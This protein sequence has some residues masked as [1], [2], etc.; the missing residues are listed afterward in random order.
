VV[1]GPDRGDRRPD[2]AH[3]ARAFVPEHERRPDRPVA[4]RRVEIA[5]AD[6]G[7]LD[8]DEHFARTGRVELGGFDRQRLSLLPQDGGVNIHGRRRARLYC[9]TI[10]RLQISE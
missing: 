4:A 9:H 7:G 6:A 2:L 8:L 10:R 3:D 5:L 1:A